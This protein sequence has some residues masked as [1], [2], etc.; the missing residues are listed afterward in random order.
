MEPTIIDG[1]P[2]GRVPLGH[3]TEA[4]RKYRDRRGWCHF[5]E[6][7]TG[8]STETMMQVV[9][10]YR[11]GSIDTLIVVAPDGVERN[12]IEKEVS[13]NWPESM[14]QPL[15]VWL[16][17]PKL[18]TKW[19]K[20][21]LE[22]ALKHKGMV[23]LAL[24]YSAFKTKDRKIKQPKGPP[25][26]VDGG[27]TWVG[28]FLKQRKAFFAIDEGWSIKNPTSKQGKYVVK[29]AT[30]AKAVRVLNG[31][32]I[33]QTPFDVYSQVLAVDPDFWRSKGIASFQ[34]FKAQFA[35]WK[36]G[37]AAGGRKFP[38]LVGFRN[39]PILTKWLGEISDRVLK[40]DVLDLPEKTYQ[41]L[42]FE[43]TPAQ[44][45][46]YNEL[47][48]NQFSL[49]PDG[50][51][52]S[53]SLV[54][55]L[56]LRLQQITS[57]YVPVDGDDPDPMRDV[58]EGNNPRIALLSEIVQGL[59]HKAII[60]TRFRRDAVLITEMMRNLKLNAVEYNGGVDQEDRG[61][62][63][64]AFGAGDAQFFIA[65][66]AAASGLTLLG[67]QSQ[68]HLACRSAIYYQNTYD[69][70]QR[71]QS[72]DRCHR[73]GQNW[74]VNYID[75][76]ASDSIDLSIIRNLKNKFQTAQSITKDRLRQWIRGEDD[77]Y[78]PESPEE[79]A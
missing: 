70:G 47:A 39:L 13:Q 33:T 16:R 5:W 44:L 76:A 22:A 27:A 74:S 62:A 12:W 56:N 35:E 25:K 20:E 57:G 30:H 42:K 34:G 67:D 29:A 2:L 19:H 55:T 8:K 15:M 60:W 50:E 7:G 17:S 79:L 52:V 6:Q 65:S 24:S 53:A 77:A 66:S 49:M 68:E 40:E 37:Y 41:L 58:T 3:Q 78:T 23:V 72:E 51:S 64:E 59:G 48:D 11:N 14:G 61:R 10:Q 69:L 1:C 31:T 18:A 75:I 54:I 73:I 9:W 4:W 21:E 46:M 38:E 45:R 43:M 32:P 26:L 28:R 36:E 63:V 71:L